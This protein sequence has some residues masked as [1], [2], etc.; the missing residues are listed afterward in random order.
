MITGNINDK[1]QSQNKIDLL[2][3]NVMISCWIYSTN[4][5]ACDADPDYIT[6]SDL[7]GDG[8]VDQDDYTLLLKEMGSQQGAVT[9]DQ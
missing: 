1:D 3:Y 4:T 6:N 9:P 8:Q 5:N 7:N 2:D